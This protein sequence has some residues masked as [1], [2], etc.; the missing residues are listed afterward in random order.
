[1]MR[2][3]SLFLSVVVALAAFVVPAQAASIQG[4]VLEA[5]LPHNGLSGDG[6][7]G[8]Y[9]KNGTSWDYLSSASV[10]GTTT[11]FLFDGLAAG[12]YSLRISGESYVTEYYNNTTLQADR[13][14]ITVAA[15]DTWDAGNIYLQHIPYRLVNASL[16]GHS[17]PAGGGTITA[18]VDVVNDTGTD[19]RLLVRVMLTSMRTAHNSTYVAG[20]LMCGS[21][22]VT[23]PARSTITTTVGISIPGTAESSVSYHARLQLGVD[24][25]RPLAGPVYAG[26]IAKLPAAAP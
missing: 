25:W 10:D 18:G 16:S 8:L 17:V 2:K 4:T 9:R 12:T 15:G 26:Y 14:E 7:V 22:Y 24:Q 1:M 19:Q 21:R 3:L 23:V 13:T 20:D 6:G 11:T 5:E